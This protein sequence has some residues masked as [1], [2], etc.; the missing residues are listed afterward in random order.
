MKIIETIPIDN[1]ISYIRAWWLKNEHHCP[2]CGSTNSVWCDN[3]NDYYEGNTYVCVFCKKLFNL[4][5]KDYSWKGN[6]Q[7][8][9]IS[10][11]LQNH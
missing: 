6:E 1:G 5:L 11:E 8:T 7:M 3:T 9:T 10:Q 2:F 4:I